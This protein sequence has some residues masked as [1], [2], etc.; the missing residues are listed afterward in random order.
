[1]KSVIANIDAFRFLDEDQGA[2]AKKFR[3]LRRPDESVLD[4]L[5]NP[6]S[7][8]A[9]RQLEPLLR[10][11][12]DAN[13]FIEATQAHLAEVFPLCWALEKDL[14]QWIADV[15]TNAQHSW[16]E[17]ATR[18]PKDSKAKDLRLVCT[19]P[20]ELSACLKRIYKVRFEGCEAQSG[21]ASTKRTPLRDDPLVHL[22][23]SLSFMLH[24][25]LRVKHHSVVPDVLSGVEGLKKIRF[26]SEEK[27]SDVA[28]ATLALENLNK[29]PIPDKARKFHDRYRERFV[30]EEYIEACTTRTYVDVTLEQLQYIRAH[31]LWRLFLDQEEVANW[32]D[33]ET[34][35]PYARRLNAIVPHSASVERMNSSQKHVHNSKR[36]SLSHANV[37]KLTFVYFNSTH[38][39]DLRV[40]S[41]QRLASEVCEATESE[42]GEIPVVDADIAGEDDGIGTDE[43][44]SSDDEGLDVYLKGP[45][46]LVMSP[47]KNISDRTEATTLGSLDENALV[48]QDDS[49]PAPGKGDGG[50]EGSSQGIRTSREGAT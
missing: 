19:T 36:L 46:E 7:Q 50:A 32:H 41:L 14:A 44:L 42:E 23:S 1:M 13:K 26:H 2:H 15:K 3:Q 38:R 11:L 33:W 49:R 28:T 48:Q 20:D 39:R 29:L 18:R 31:N 6:V 27:K 43:I 35:I 45:D 12:A 24:K 16:I 5:F 25:C 9:V 4:V 30:N 40:S 17:R 47:C 34:L 8:T 37:E 21:E 22:A 10:G